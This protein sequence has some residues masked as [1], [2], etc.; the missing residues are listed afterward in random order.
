MLFLGYKKHTHTKL[1]VY[2]HRAI[3]IE[4]IF[5]IAREK[6]V[7]EEFIEKRKLQADVIC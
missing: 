3:N 7:D 2:R 6:W 4:H 1:Y 5:A